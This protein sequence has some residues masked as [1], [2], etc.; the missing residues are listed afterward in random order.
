MVD[1]QRSIIVVALGIAVFF[2][3][4]NPGRAA[5]RQVLQ[6]HIP[7]VVSHLQPIGRLP[8][9]DRLNLAI[10][11]PLRNE[12]AL[13]DLLL[14]IYDPASPNFHQYL[15]P[16]QFTEM[17]GPTEDD[18]QTLAA[19]MT[20][21]GL[22][23]TVTHPNRVVLDVS[24]SVA[25]IERVF[26]VT[27]R[28]YQHPNENRIFYAPDVEPSIGLAIPILHVSG[29]DNYSLPHP[30]FKIQPAGQAAGVTPQSGSGANGSYIGKDFRAAYAPGVTLTGTGQNV[31]LV[32]YDGYYSNDIAF[33][34][35]EAGLSPVTLT[36][37]PIDGG[38]TT[39][40]GGNSEVCLDIEMVISMAPGVSKIYVYE[41]PNPS[42]W[43]DMLN[44][45][46]N[47]NVARQISCSWGGGP[48]DPTSEVIF[49][50]MSAQGQSFYNAS[51]DSDAF[52]GSIP[53]PSES[54]N[55]T[56]VGGTTLTMVGTGAGYQSEKV[57][58]WGGGTGSSGGISPTYSIPS[59]QQGINM[60]LNQ[61]STTKRNIPDVALTG[62]NVYVRYN[63]GS[64][65]IF[66]GTSCAAPLWAGFTALINQQ[67]AALG[68]S[69]VGFINPAIYTIGKGASYN[70][71]FH[72]ITTG[73]NTWSG[74]PSK[75]YATNGYDL[76]TGWGTPNGQNLIDALAGPV[77][78]LVISP[79]SGFST[80]GAAGGP[81]NLVSQAF[82]LT[83]AGTGTLNWQIGST[84]SWL[85][86]SSTIGILAAAGQNI[87][88]IGL[89]TVASNLVIGTYT[90]NV[91]F[92]NINSGS[93]Q[94]RQFK[95]QVVQP[96]AVSP[97]NGFTTTG[98]VGGPFNVVA[99]TIALTNVGAGP[100]SWSLVNTSLWLDASPAG[101]TLPANG[102]SALVTASLN[103]AANYLANGVYTAN[104]WFTNLTS[105]TAVMV[106][107][108][109]QVGGSIVQNGGFE[110]GNFSFWGLANDFYSLVD[111]NG[112]ISGIAPHSGSYLAAFGDSGTLGTLS[113]TLPTVANQSYVLSLWLNSPNVLLV[114]GGRATNNTPN[115]FRVSWNGNVLFDQVNI[116]QIGWTNLQFIVTAT[117]SNTVLQFGEE[118][119]TWYLG[120]D[121]VSAVPIPY[122][123]FRSVVK[124]AGSNAVV[125]SW[126][127]M[128][129]FKYQVQYLTNLTTTNWIS[130]STNTAVGPI[131][132]VTNSFGTDPQ[133][134]YRIRRLP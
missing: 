2:G 35:S 108:V 115:E 71:D 13:D 118:M 85:N 62:D 87:V 47:D 57:W 19:F 80:F 79:S 20:A 119:D 73:N 25:D 60:T 69:G 116:G 3:A 75:F 88:T 7:E 46:A 53:F 68:K 27:L 12:Q 9:T 78:A 126:N 134:Y 31:G 14:E 103:P 34:I 8:A 50:Q 38:V 72:D 120:L 26:Q 110:A 52:T 36:N 81:F 58:N 111:H 93:V 129:G 42:P 48:A 55:I 54:T 106:P 131:L 107:V 65:G 132:S 83:N 18:Y 28:T 105:H 128:A 124:V 77:D 22:T 113:Q 130:L 109:L 23:V 64:K 59:W 63:N 97:T 6:G 95:L 101:G 30:N 66:G 17:F 82:S 1:L 102:S 40:G 29:L 86:V 133:R 32:Q 127:T 123:S 89:N 74:S 70:L 39:P 33:Y 98:P 21:N 122:P 5:D 41:A 61:G 24:G 91:W 104:L 10:G 15:T 16:G 114:S 96:L 45:I 11:L 37:V 67:A 125:F 4:A 84:S 100:L 56:Q 112:A 76:C 44:R 121:D 117:G 51:G 43:P 94:N 90:A 99:Q 49:K 92:T